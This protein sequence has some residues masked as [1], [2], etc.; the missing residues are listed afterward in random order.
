MR[1]SYY[2]PLEYS[3]HVEYTAILSSSRLDVATF[4]FPDNSVPFVGHI[5]GHKVTLSH[6]PGYT[7]I[8][9]KT[10]SGEYCLTE[11]STGALC[12]TIDFAK[13][14]KNAFDRLMDTIFCSDVLGNRQHFETAINEYPQR[15]RER[16]QSLTD[17]PELCLWEYRCRYRRERRERQRCLQTS[18]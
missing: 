8:M 6:L 17:D 14:Y 10:P 1:I 12:A 16:V 9:H 2:L 5:T 15:I 7:F 3:E 4:Y 13:S 11:E 18:A